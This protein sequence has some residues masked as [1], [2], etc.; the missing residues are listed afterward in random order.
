M[1][2]IIIILFIIPLIS[3]SQQNDFLTKLF[4]DSVQIKN[5]DFKLELAGV[6]NT[7]AQKVYTEYYYGE[8][9]TSYISEIIFLEDLRVAR[10]FESERF[11]GTRNDINRV[12]YNE[13]CTWNWSGNN[14]NLQMVS[15]YS[16]DLFPT[17]SFLKGK[18]LTIID[19]DSTN[20]DYLFSVSKSTKYDN[21]GHKSMS[22][23]LTDDNEQGYTINTIIINEQSYIIFTKDEMYKLGF[24]TEFVDDSKFKVICG[25]E[26][27]TRYLRD[28]Y[29][30]SRYDYMF[31]NC[32]CR[33]D[34]D[35]LSLFRKKTKYMD[36][37]YN[38][39]QDDL[40]Y[41]FKLEKKN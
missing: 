38:L 35:Y 1:K 17:F 39:D 15:P 3:F 26:E 8:L 16:L 28:D 4:L 23:N 2:K 33:C 7:K 40:L 20:K 9:Q 29:Y 37:T 12:A 19:I 30:N 6:I 10:Q 13:S 27:K 34:G 14:S 36:N 21:Y 41:L 31:V 24:S 18:L 5:Q 11:M 25:G 32:V 22:F